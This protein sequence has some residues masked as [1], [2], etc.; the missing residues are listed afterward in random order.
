MGEKCRKRLERILMTGADARKPVDI[1]AM[2]EAIRGRRP[3]RQ[4]IVQ[5]HRKI[6]VARNTKQPYYRK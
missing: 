3:T 2:F 6:P 4:E 5:L 1:L